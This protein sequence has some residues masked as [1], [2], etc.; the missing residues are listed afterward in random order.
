MSQGG[1]QNAS[2][3]Q[4]QV[5]L[6]DFKPGLGGKQSGT[7]TKMEFVVLPADRQ[8][9]SAS[10]SPSI[11]ITYTCHLAFPNSSISPLQFE[12]L[13]LDLRQSGTVVILPR[14]P[15][16][17]VDNDGIHVFVVVETGGKQFGPS[18]VSC[19]PSFHSIGEWALAS[20]GYIH[21]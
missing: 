5:A 17:I 9:P 6:V 12:S 20:C 8:Q 18:F 11:T 1:G 13:R 2:N 10:L 19:F 16:C 4:C 7:R 21:Y 15:R 14:E 3:R